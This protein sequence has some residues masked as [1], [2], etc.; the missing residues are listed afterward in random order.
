MAQGESQAEPQVATGQGVTEEKPKEKVVEKK[1]YDATIGNF[2]S[3]SVDVL[4]NGQ[5]YKI[6]RVH[7][8][9]KKYL[10]PG[11]STKLELSLEEFEKYRKK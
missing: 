2:D 9:D 3:S 7:F 1:V 8:S 5:L 11:D 6:P 10:A 4:I